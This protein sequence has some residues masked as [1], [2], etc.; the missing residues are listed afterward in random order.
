MTPQQSKAW[1]SVRSLLAA[2]EQAR[3]Q[4]AN[5]DTSVEIAREKLD[6]RIVLRKL[7]KEK[8]DAARD[9]T[10][11]AAKQARWLDSREGKFR[12]GQV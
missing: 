4:F 7:L 2:Q 3:Q 9:A 10:K 5:A 8:L 1:D 12:K 6:A 11:E